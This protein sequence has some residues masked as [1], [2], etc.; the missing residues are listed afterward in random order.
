MELSAIGLQVLA[1]RDVSEFWFWMNMSII[2]QWYMGIDGV[3]V[4][5]FLCWIDWNIEN[6]KK[7]MGMVWY[8]YFKDEKGTFLD[9]FWISS[10][11]WS[12][13]EYNGSF[14][15]SL[16]VYAS[17]KSTR[18]ESTWNAYFENRTFTY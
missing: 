10:T 2:Y 15:L 11:N 7:W 18:M 8:W 14:E 4:C 17:I 1:I 5:I 3:Y 6:D 16:N 9:V 12:D 13:L